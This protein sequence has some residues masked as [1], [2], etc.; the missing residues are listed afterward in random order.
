[1]KTIRSL[2]FIPAEERR[3]S[4]IGQTNADAYIID[5]EDSI[6]LEDKDISLQRTITFLA[7][8]A[9][10][11]IF[12]RINKQRHISELDALKHFNVGFMLP[13]I[14]AEADYS[15]AE[16]SLRDHK[17]IALIE[18]PRALLNA[19]AIGSI[20]WVSALAFGAEDFSVATN[21]LNELCT[22]AMPKQ[23]LVLAAKANN[24]K[25]AIIPGFTWA[26]KIMSHFTPFIN[27]AFGSMSYDAEKG[28]YQKYTTK[29]SI[30]KMEAKYE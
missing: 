21:T 22:L 11:N 12:V 4:K 2:L 20:S 28:E 5:L 17:V 23:M 1:M 26:L 9:A 7:S 13:K 24:K 14:E 6:A 27:K 8:C 3:L 15:D 18:T 10:D 29:E 30:K 19:D 16:E 25:I